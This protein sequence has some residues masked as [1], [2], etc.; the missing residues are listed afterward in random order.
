M[1]STLWAVLIL[2]LVVTGLMALATAFF[3][4][5]GALLAQ[6]LPLSLFQASIL[7]IG[8]TLAFC[9]II[10]LILS[11]RRIPLL[12]YDDELDDP[13]ELGD[14]ELDDHIPDS[15][16]LLD[17]PDFSK[18]G[19]NQLCPCG[20]GRKFKNCCAITAAR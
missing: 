20:S 15:D 2:M 9:I 16:K 18:I 17:K 10:H 4:G 12:D 6:W 1:R 19:R 11:I 3:I 7:A 5:F 8:A 14:D 13:Y